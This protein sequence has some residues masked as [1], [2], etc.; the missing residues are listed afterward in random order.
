MF[1]ERCGP[2]EAR[3][4][5]YA[6]ELRRLRALRRRLVIAIRAVDAAGIAIRTASE[7]WPRDALA[8]LEQGTKHL[9]ALEVRLRELGMRRP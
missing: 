5:P 2:W 9:A 7:R 6:A 8:L 1:H 3:P 4:Y